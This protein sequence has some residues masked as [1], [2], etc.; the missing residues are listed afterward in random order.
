MNLH[1]DEIFL[2]TLQPKIRNVIQQN[3]RQE[4]N[5]NSVNNKNG[6]THFSRY[7]IVKTEEDF[8]ANSLKL[9]Y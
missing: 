2:I 5:D 3:L 8:A 6:D 9:N 7:F 1:V 4:L